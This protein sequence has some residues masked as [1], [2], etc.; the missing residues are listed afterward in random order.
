[1]MLLYIVLVLNIILFVISYPLST[2]Y[3][4]SFDTSQSGVNGYFA[5]TIDESAGLSYYDFKVDL[6]QYSNPDSCDLSQGIKYHIHSYWTNTTSSNTYGKAACGTT[7]GHFDPYL[8]CSGSSQYQN[9]P[10]TYPG[11]LCP[12][13]NRAA[14]N[15][16]Y[17]CSSTSFAAG[18]LQ[19]CEVGDL[20]GKFGI[21]T[22]STTVYASSSLLIDPLGPAI[23]DYGYGDVQSV[24][25]YTNMWN[26]I[27]FHCKDTTNTRLFCAQFLTTL[28]SC[29]SQGAQFTP[30]PESDTSKTY[31][32]KTFNVVISLS[33]VVAFLF[34]A[35]TSILVVRYKS[36]AKDL[37]KSVNDPL[38]QNY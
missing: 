6:S 7:G 17:P 33:V 24:T 26:S 3:C 8:A 1:M 34:G 13:I 9:T 4:A 22:S 28:D 38:I 37:D 20:S 21:V 35:L 19:G 10:V 30:I 5:M 23:I 16:T 11:P 12:L 27:V 36:S 2:S 14:P 15:Y 31:T 25:E 18:Y 29:N 32:A